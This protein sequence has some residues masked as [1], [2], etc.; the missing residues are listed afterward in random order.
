MS[1]ELI[2]LLHVMTDNVL[3]HYQHVRIAASRGCPAEDR[4]KLLELLKDFY[5]LAT[6]LDYWTVGNFWK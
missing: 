6:Q 2:E 3:D 4:D 5:D 1:E